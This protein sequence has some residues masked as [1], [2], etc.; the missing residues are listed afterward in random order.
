[1]ANMYPSKK[2]S[3]GGGLTETIIWTNPDKG[4][5]YY[6]AFAAQVVTLTDSIAN[7][8]YLKFVCIRGHRTSNPNDRISI[9]IARKDFVNYCSTPGS[10]DYNGLAISVKRGNTNNT[11]YYRYAHYASNTQVKFLAAIGQNSSGSGSTSNDY[12]V[13]INIIGLK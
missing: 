5:T 13:P 9:I 4:E 6:P 10:A 7:Y 12:L 2:A 1:M 3:G 11:Q 8:D